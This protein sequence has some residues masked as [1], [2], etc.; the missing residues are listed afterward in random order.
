MIQNSSFCSRSI[1]LRLCEI[2]E[3]NTFGT[4]KN[5]KF[6]TA[7]LLA[8][9]GSGQIDFQDQQAIV[10]LGFGKIQKKT[11]NFAEQKTSKKTSQNSKTRKPQK[12]N[13]KNLPKRQKPQK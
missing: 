3:F 5:Q 2:V 7:N 8:N 4:M 13:P 1:A 9:W 6:C 12:K 11:R 10:F